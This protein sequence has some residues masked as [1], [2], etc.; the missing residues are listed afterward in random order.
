MKPIDF[1]RIFFYVCYENWKF[2]MQQM[3]YTN[4]EKKTN[5]WYYTCIYS[6]EKICEIRSL[7]K[8]AYRV[9]TIFTIILIY[10]FQENHWWMKKTQIG[11]KIIFWRGQVFQKNCVIM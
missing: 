4:I 6:F 11:I 9:R 8:Q 3:C 7:K 1:N 2:V 5:K 10:M